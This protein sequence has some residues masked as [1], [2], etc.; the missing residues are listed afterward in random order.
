LFYTTLDLG[1]EGFQKRFSSLPGMKHIAKKQKVSH[2]VIKQTRLAKA[3]RQGA[4]DFFCNDGSVRF[5]FKMIAQLPYSQRQ[6]CIWAALARC[7]SEV[8]KAL[9]RDAPEALRTNADRLFEVRERVGV[10]SPY[11]AWY[12]YNIKSTNMP[13]SHVLH[14]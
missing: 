11:N 8:I 1:K 13:I 7:Q 6:E 2:Q 9:A 12:T 5:L 14:A 4:D 10:S 3:A